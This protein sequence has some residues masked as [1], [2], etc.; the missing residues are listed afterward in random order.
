MKYIYGYRNDMLEMEN[1]R[2]Y[3]QDDFAFDY[4]PKC[5]MSL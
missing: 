5:G 2:A 1:C 3:V 4:C